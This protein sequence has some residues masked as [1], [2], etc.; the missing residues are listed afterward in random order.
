MKAVRQCSKT[1]CNRASVAT[2]TYVYADSTAVLGP[3][4]VS[5]EPHTYDLC[6]VHA[7]R[8]TAPRGWDVVRLVSDLEPAGPSTDDID[9]L[10]SAVR[11]AAS[12]PHDRYPAERAA[13]AYRSEPR[14][15][16]EG[17]HPPDAT[18][19]RQRGHLRVV[20]GQGKE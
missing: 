20:R 10:A 6:E 15:L 11:E 14:S 12:R 7:E 5:A 8:L 13:V 18:S 17:H 19:G 4:A 2:L 16:T 1:S 3:L 9:A